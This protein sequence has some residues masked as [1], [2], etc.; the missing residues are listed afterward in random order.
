M[1][2]KTWACGQKLGQKFLRRFTPANRET[3][4]YTSEF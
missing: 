2:A 4:L 1:W 3:L